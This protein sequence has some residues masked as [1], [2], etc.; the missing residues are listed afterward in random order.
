MRLRHARTASPPLPSA[1]PLARASGGADGK[2]GDA[3]RACL[4]LIELVRVFEGQSA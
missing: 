1:P 4:S 2:G 3:V